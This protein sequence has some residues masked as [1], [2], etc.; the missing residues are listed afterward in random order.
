[1]T[2]SDEQRARLASDPHRP[3]YHFLPPGSWMNDPNGLIQWRGQYHMF[4]QYNPAR[5]RFGRIHWGHAVSDDLARWRDLPIALSPTPGGP[6][7]DGCWSGCIVDD[8]GV[9][10]MIYTGLRD[11]VQRPCLATSADDLL[12]WTKYAGNPL[13]AAPP[14]EM[15]QIDFRDHSVWKEDGIWYQVIGSSVPSVGGAALLYCS[16]DLRSWEYIHPLYTGDKQTTGTVWE[17]P[18]FFPLGDKHVLVISPIPLRKAIYLVGNYADR[19][20]TPERIGEID[21]GGHLYAPQTLRDDQ[22]RRI[23]FGWLWEGRSLE[24]HEAA[25]WAGVMSLPRVLSLRPDGWVGFEPAPELAAL[26]GA[27]RR[28]EAVPLL[29]M[30]Y[31]VPEIQGNSLE[32]MVDLAPGDAARCGVDV[33]RS[34]DGAEYTRI[35]YDRAQRRLEI[36]RRHSSSKAED[37]HDVQGGDLELNEG[38]PLRLRIFLD[39]SVVE[40]FA[41]GRFCATSRVYPSRRNSLGVALFAEGGASEARSLDMW[42]IG[43]IWA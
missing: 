38:E 42:E 28:W 21:V 24:A 4:Y 35:V 20:F 10:T 27:H 23:M 6:D 8:D 2:S 9:P 43:S 17:C 12:T 1:M 30:E 14:P 41:N 29:S 25:G 26:R 13:I 31:I 3:H 40:V 34:P 32:I 11:P 39:R 15:D 7:A 33:L 37:Q 22:G 18:D 19:R 16:R 5:A 36:D